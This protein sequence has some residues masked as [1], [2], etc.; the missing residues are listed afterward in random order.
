MEDTCLARANMCLAHGKH[1]E[2]VNDHVLES[3]K[4]N[5]IDG[6]NTKRVHQRHGPKG[7]QIVF[8]LLKDIW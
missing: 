1:V 3:T 4:S 8:W 5:K 6:I 7:Q 2:K